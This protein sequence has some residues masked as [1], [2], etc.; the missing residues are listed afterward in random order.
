MLIAALEG[1]YHFPKPRNG[2]VGDKPVEDRRFADIACAWRYGAENYAKWG[3]S[4]EES[5]EKQRQPIQRID[6]NI[7]TWLNKG[8]MSA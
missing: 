7:T 1:G 8:E 6:T 4:Y 2:V 5:R 3:L